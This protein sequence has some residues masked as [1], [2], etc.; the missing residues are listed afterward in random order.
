MSQAVTDAIAAGLAELSRVVDTPV[1]PFGYGTDLSCQ[2]DLAEDFGE[3]DPNSMLALA[4]AL[5]RRL[6][7]PR[8]HLPDDADYGI[9]LKGAVNRGSARAD[10]L[11]LAGQIR[12]ELEK[13]DRV[14]RA[15]VSV[16]LSADGAQLAVKT[17]ITPRDPRTSDFSLTLAVTSA[18]VLLEELAA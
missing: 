17:R 7:C 12:A 10:L 4:E 5:V 6:D 11:A 18:A 8:G 15:S 16:T 3:V 1:A 14:D 2:T 13:D 9:D